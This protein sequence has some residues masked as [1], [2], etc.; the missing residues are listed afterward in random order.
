MPSYLHETH[1]GRT[2]VVWHRTRFAPRPRKMLT[3]GLPA[4]NLFV[5]GISCPYL[6]Y[7]G[8]SQASP[9]P[10]LG[11]HHRG[12]CVPQNW[13]D[14][15]SRV[16]PWRERPAARSDSQVLV[17]DAEWR[18]QVLDWWE[19]LP[20]QWTE[21]L[22]T[23]AESGFVYWKLAVGKAESGH[24]CQPRRRYPSVTREGYCR[25]YL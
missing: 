5:G 7:P 8:V 1:V 2:L 17:G 14:M 19:S 3:A 12:P 18:L 23:P 15:L 11:S 22:Y 21:A 20:G 10:E 24:F 6:A 25:Q 4:L 13:R 9:L 16:S